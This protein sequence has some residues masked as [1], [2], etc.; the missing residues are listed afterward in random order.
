MNQLLKSL[1][2]CSTPRNLNSQNI[3]NN[4]FNC[5]TRLDSRLFVDIFDKEEKVQ[6]KAEMLMKQLQ[7]QGQ[8]IKM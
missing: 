4:L 2:F 1:L 5:L 6:A 8:N 3:S 7:K